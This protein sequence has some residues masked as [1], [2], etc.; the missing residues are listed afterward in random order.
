MQAGRIRCCANHFIAPHLE[1]VGFRAVAQRGASLTNTVLTLLNQPRRFPALLS[2]ASLGRILDPS[3]AAQ[4]LDMATSH[5]T[6]RG[7]WSGHPPGPHLDGVDPGPPQFLVQQAP[8]H[9]SLCPGG[10][11]TKGASQHELA[12]QSAD[13]LRERDQPQVIDIAASRHCRAGRQG[14]KKR[15]PGVHAAR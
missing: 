4:E 11:E 3:N 9:L 5:F 6:G 15:H 2:R 7:F 1:L 8:Q 13:L 12:S 10:F 14:Q